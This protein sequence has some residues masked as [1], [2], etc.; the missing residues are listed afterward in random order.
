MHQNEFAIIARTAAIT[1]VDPRPEAQSR[2]VSRAEPLS[3]R[4]EFV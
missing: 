2:V 3:G 1:V 4:R